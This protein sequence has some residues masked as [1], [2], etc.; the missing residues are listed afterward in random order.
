MK[1][2]SVTDD[3]FHPEMSPLNE[4][5]S[6]MELIPVTDDVFHPEMSPLKD[7]AS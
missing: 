6:N 1:L 7:L 2:I 5:A 4:D 3:V